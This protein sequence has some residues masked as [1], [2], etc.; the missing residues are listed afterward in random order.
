MKLALAGQPNCGKSTIFNYVSGYKAITSNFPGTT[1]KYTASQIYID[2]HTCECIDLPG[3]YSLTSTDAAGYESRKYLLSGG[4]DVVI[5]VVDASLLS[6]SLELTIQLMEMEIPMVLCLNMIDE[7][8]R[9][10]IEIDLERLSSILGIPVIETIGVKGMGLKELFSAALRVFKRGR[11]AKTIKYSRD[12]EEIIDLMAAY[13]KDDLTLPKR[14]AAIKLLEGDEYFI[15]MVRDGDEE[16]GK[17]IAELKKILSSRHGRSSDMVIS[18]ERHSQ[19]MNTFERVA[20]VVHPPLADIRDQVDNIVMHPYIG[21]ILLALVFYGFFNFVFGIGEK[22]EGPLMGFFEF[23]SQHLGKSMGS[24]SMGYLILNGI[25]QGIAGGIAVVLP[26]LV[27]FL[28]GLAFLE[29]VGYLPRVAFLVDSFMHRIGLHGKSILPL[30]M[31][32][33]CTVPAIMGTRI[34]ESNRDRFIVSVLASLVPCAARTTI[35]FGMVA[36]FI[37]P[38]AALA[39]YALNIA[40]IALVGRI[41]SMILPEVTSG[42]I[43]EIPVYHLPSI[44]TTLAKSWYRIREY[45]VIAW[46]MLIVGSVILSL[47]EF[48]GMDR[49]VNAMLWPVTYILGLPED[50]GTTL[51]FGILR[52]ELSMIMLIQALETPHILTVMS[53]VQVMVFTVFVIFYIPCLATIAVLWRE[54]GSKRAFFTV[55]LTLILATG[56]ALATRVLGAFIW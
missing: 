2:G 22:V 30:I 7:A 31:G 18:S 20:K 54:I 45:I 11:K 13:I 50:V 56:L 10:G 14:L 1:V 15:A 24:E 17:R 25:L 33:G 21:Y 55:L 27:P 19:A 40:V 5:N 42:M 44:R 48:W 34:L 3:T 12:V 8:R 16:L 43:M 23:F 9:K 28:I 53:K 4:A 32:Y 37:N 49:F 29:D 36:F 51:I 6:R 46:P 26:Y 47:M 41:L 39:I 52:K 35:I 38:N